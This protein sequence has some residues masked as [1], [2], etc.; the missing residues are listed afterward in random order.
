MEFRWRYQDA[1]GRD[2][3][4]PDVT[5]A[6]Q[7]EAEDWF[8]DQWRDLLE[9]GVEQVTLL[10]SETEVYGPMSLHPAS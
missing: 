8:S 10:R 6:E 7:T 3:A 5:F 1:H 4:G 2:V 9:A